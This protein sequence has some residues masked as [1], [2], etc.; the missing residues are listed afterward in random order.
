M[1]K[2]VLVAD[3]DVGE[4]LRRIATEQ[5]DV[6][7]WHVQRVGDGLGHVHELR[8]ATKRMRA[9]VRMVRYEI[10]EDRYQAL[11]TAVRDVS[12]ELSELRTAIVRLET[13]EG[14]VAG[15]ALLGSSSGG[16]SDSLAADVMRLHDA[17]VG[18]LRL[19]DGLAD[20]LRDVREEVGAWSFPSDFVPASEGFRRT[21]RRGR[22][23]MARAYSE[24]KTE[25]FHRWRKEVKYLRHQIEVLASAVSMARPNLGPTLEELGDGLGMDHD[26]ADLELAV[27]KTAGA[28][29]SY[30][31]DCSELAASIGQRRRTLH[32]DLVPLGESV[33]TREPH[34]FQHEIAM[35]W[36]RWKAPND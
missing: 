19:I 13:L 27:S 34:E 6:A 29:S 36:W 3:E 30:R 5:I 1:A 18:D 8:K 17:V 32:D 33:Y 14:L 25:S 2:F 24:G 20:R 28:R 11:N 9:V 21:Y 16:L 15:D 4:G 35:Y 10:D 22:I 12:R 23:R 26:L 7:S 31:F